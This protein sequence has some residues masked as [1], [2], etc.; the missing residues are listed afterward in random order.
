MLFWFSLAAC[1]KESIFLCSEERGPHP[2]YTQGQEEGPRKE[3]FQQGNGI[4]F[5]RIG[6]I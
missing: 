1:I 4:H 3:F 6:F 2:N 5:N